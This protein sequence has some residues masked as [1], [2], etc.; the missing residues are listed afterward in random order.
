LEISSGFIP[1]I[2]GKIRKQ[3]IDVPFGT[4]KQQIQL[5]IVCFKEYGYISNKKM[6]FH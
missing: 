3:E 4:R 6:N 2:M 5:E 1:E